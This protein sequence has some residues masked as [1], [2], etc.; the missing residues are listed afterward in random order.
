[1]IKDR[2]RKME[3]SCDRI[4]LLAIKDFDIASTAIIKIVSGLG[5]KFIINDSKTYLKQLKELKG[6]GIKDEKHKTHHSWLIRM[7]A[8][9]MFSTSIEYTRFIGYKD[10]GKSLEDIDKT[11]ETYLNELTGIDPN[12]QELEIYEQALLFILPKYLYDNFPL[13]ENKT[14]V[15]INRFGED[16]TKQILNYLSSSSRNQYNLKYDEHIQKIATIINQSL[17]TKLFKEVI[18]L[19]KLLSENI[20]SNKLRLLEIEL[21]L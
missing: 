9:K 10:N 13:D 8:L 4:G 11:I 17:R 3:L 15:F 18:G 14:K 12:K 5:S 7:Q 2:S 6:I 20:S 21:G 16:K 1:M 19:M